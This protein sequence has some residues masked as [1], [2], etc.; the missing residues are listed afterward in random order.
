MNTKLRI[1]F[2][3]L[4]FALV[5]CG[6][7]T[8]QPQ[9]PP[10]QPEQPVIEPTEPPVQQPAGSQNLFE[11]WP[12]EYQNIALPSELIGVLDR[13]GSVIFPPPDIT[14]LVQELEAFAAS[15]GFDLAPYDLGRSVSFTSDQGYSYIAAPVKS[16]FFNN[17]FQKE[18]SNGVLTGLLFDQNGAYSEVPDLY[19]VRFFDD[20]AVLHSPSG[21][22]IVLTVND[23]QF[24]WI[25]QEIYKEIPVTF[26]IKGSCYLCWSLDSRCGCLICR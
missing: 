14:P 20:Q 3:A 24:F 18:Y 7:I 12:P 11:G 23:K 25:N 16:E 1:L 10:E 13:G 17:N 22:D 26:F 9:I 15:I 4:L 2:A 5:A 21:K 6:P 19:E 8:E